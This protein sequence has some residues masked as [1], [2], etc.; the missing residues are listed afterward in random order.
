MVHKNNEILFKL[1]DIFSILSNEAFAIDK[2]IDYISEQNIQKALI[3]TDSK[4]TLQ[5]LSNPIATNTQI[6]IIQNKLQHQSSRTSIVL[7]WI[8]SHQGII[9]NEKAD[10]AAKEA[11]NNGIDNTNVPIPRED[12]KREIRKYTWAKWN[13][14]WANTTSKLAAV[15]ENVWQKTPDSASRKHQCIITRLRIGHTNLT[16]RHI[17]ARDETK[18]CEACNVPITVAHILCECT[19][20]DRGQIDL[21][22]TLKECLNDKNTIPTV[23]QL[24]KRMKIIDEI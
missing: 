19:Q 8:P 6:T 12:H 3:L 7:V 24:L 10:Q 11:I 14:I 16:H 1:P 13:M 15:R 22:S 23:I 21:P 5:A 4:S 18:I 9:G 17:L 2:S 20:A